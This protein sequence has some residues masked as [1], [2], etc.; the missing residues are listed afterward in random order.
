MPHGG[1]RKIVEARHATNRSRN[2][3][4]VEGVLGWRALEFLG[5]CVSGGVGREL[6]GLQIREA[7]LSQS[8]LKTLPDSN[9]SRAPE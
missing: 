9:L 7:T 1:S 2:V 4:E 5:K 6:G 8:A 3:G